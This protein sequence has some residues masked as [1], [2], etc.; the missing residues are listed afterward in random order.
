MEAGEVRKLVLS[1][2]TAVTIYGAQEISLVKPLQ[3]PL[4]WHFN[5]VIFG[6]IPEEE[7]ASGL[8]WISRNLQSYFVSKG[9]KGGEILSLRVTKP[10]AVVSSK[11]PHLGHLGEVRGLDTKKLDGGNEVKDRIKV[12][13]I[14]PTCIKLHPVSQIEE[15]GIQPWIWPSPQLNKKNKGLVALEKL[16]LSVLGKAAHE[17]GFFRVLSASAKL[18]NKIEVDF[19]VDQLLNR[20]DFSALIPGM[21]SSSRTDGKVVLARLRFK[22]LFEE[23]PNRKL[24]PVELYP[25]SPIVSTI[26]ISSISHLVNGT[27]LGLPPIL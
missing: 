17:K 7:E 5:P 3:L 21:T 6:N 4:P 19:E 14:S 27:D 10:R 12:K 9:R 13:R 15:K 2:G 8:K 1:E 23:M 18:V 25:L 11:V 22:A 20:E 24:K 16:I 26:K